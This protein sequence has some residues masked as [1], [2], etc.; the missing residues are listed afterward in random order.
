M[1][2]SFR[3]NSIVC[4][5]LSKDIFFSGKVKSRPKVDDEIVLVS[6]IGINLEDCGNGYSGCDSTRTIDST[7]E[8]HID[9]SKIIA[10]KYVT[11]DVVE[12]VRIIDEKDIPT[13]AEIN[14]YSDRGYCIG[15]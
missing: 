8:I 3:K 7:E 12:K 5:Y 6:Q 14:N 4:V 13:K 11:A 2:Y 9:S 15:K 10:W 1:Q